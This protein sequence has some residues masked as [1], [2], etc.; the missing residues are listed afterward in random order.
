LNFKWNSLI[1]DDTLLE[2]ESTLM[3]GFKFSF[4]LYLMPLLSQQ[5]SLATASAVSALDFNDKPLEKTFKTRPDSDGLFK[6]RELGK[7]RNRG[8]PEH[9]EK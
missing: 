4:C 5:P 3:D 7:N 8:V 2:E 6:R 1:T 9:R